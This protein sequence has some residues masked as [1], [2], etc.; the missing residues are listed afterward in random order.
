MGPY[1][2]SLNGLYNQDSTSFLFDSLTAGNYVYKVEDAN[3]CIL[4]D[5]ITISEPNSLVVNYTIVQKM[6]LKD[7]MGVLL[8]ML[9]GEL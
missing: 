3:G 2:Y 6:H 7:Q 5:V 4:E 9:V 8:Q 1:F